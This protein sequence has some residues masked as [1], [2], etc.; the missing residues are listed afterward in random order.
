MPGTLRGDF[1]LVVTENIVHGSDSPQSAEREL[2]LFFG[3]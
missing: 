3:S 2:D 1:G